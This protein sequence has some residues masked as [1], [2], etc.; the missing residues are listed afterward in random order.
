MGS[1]IARTR[2]ALGLDRDRRPDYPAPT[3]IAERKIPLSEEW[4]W[5][6]LLCAA[7]FAAFGAL[8]LAAANRRRRADAIA[9]RPK[10]R[11][12]GNDR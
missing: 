4:F 12:G 7:P 9:R 2:S 11:I 6:V 8:E 3:A 1:S 10:S 5:A